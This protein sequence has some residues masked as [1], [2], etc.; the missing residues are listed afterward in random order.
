MTQHYPVMARP[1]GP[2]LVYVEQGEQPTCHVLDA[3]GWDPGRCWSTPC[4]NSR[5]LR[6]KPMS[7]PTARQILD[8]PMGTNDAGA[9]TI[10]GYLVAL[11]EALWDQGEGFSGKRPLG[12]SGW[13]YDLYAALGNAG[14]IRCAFDSDG[15]IDDMDETAG[16]RLIKA[17]IAALGE[18]AQ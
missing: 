12:N 2:A 1:D 4:P 13:D 6:G 17:A 9:A 16:N 14:H 5:F 8:T 7:E 11:L 3:D 15:Y 18:A 10:R